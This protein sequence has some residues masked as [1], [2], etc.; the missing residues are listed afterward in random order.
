MKAGMYI[1][2]HF[3]DAIGKREKNKPV[4]CMC[5]P[6]ESTDYILTPKKIDVYQL[7]RITY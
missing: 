5:F 1:L 2:C 4:F 6:R 7:M 3:Y